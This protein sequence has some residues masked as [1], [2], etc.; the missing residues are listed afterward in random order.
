PLAGY[1]GQVS[2]CQLSI[3]GI[4]AVVWGHLGAH[5]ELWALPVAVLVAAAVGA[6]IALPALRL[7]GIYLA[8]GTA[9]F[10]VI[11]DRW[12]FTLPAFEVLGVRIALFDQGS[13]PVTGP[14]LFGLH[15]TSPVQLL[16]FAAICLALVSLGVAALRRGR[17]GRRLIALR[18]S[19]A[20]YATIGG[21]LLGAKTAV[22]ALSAGIAGLGGALYGMQLQTVTAE[23]FNLVAGLPVF[24]VAVIGG[25][26]AV[27]AGLFTGLAFVVPAQLLDGLGTWAHDVT[28]LLVALAGMGLAH[29][30]GGVL[31]GMREEWAP[32]A[33]DRTLLPALL[34]VLAGCWLLAALDVADAWLWLT[35]A[36][37]AAVTL[38]VRATARQQAPADIPLE[39]WGV[40]RAW[41][42]EDGEVLR[43]A[44][45]AR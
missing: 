7:S 23:Q 36:V 6:L 2:L 26:G 29:S 32:L 24:L 11:L 44:T 4:G 19:E 15:L 10:A 38:R 41:R 14:D 33:R 25:L 42:P 5:G 30:P 22:F 8:L 27:G 28:A 39:W 18:D 17:F 40:R 1:A 13:V 34:G 21:R 37:V 12:I 31:A 20:A 43:R 16:L 3:A 35:A 45:A 9:A